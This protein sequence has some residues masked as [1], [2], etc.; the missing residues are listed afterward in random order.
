MNGGCDVTR[1]FPRSVSSFLPLQA[2][3][4]MLTRSICLSLAKVTQNF[5]KRNYYW[6]G[7]EYQKQRWWNGLRD[8]A[9]E[10][11]RFCIPGIFF[12]LTQ[13]CMNHSYNLISLRCILIVFIYLP[14]TFNESPPPR[15]VLS[16]G[17]YS[18]LI[19]TPF[20][21]RNIVTQ[22]TKSFRT[23]VAQYMQLSTTRIKYIKH[24]GATW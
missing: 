16:K 3:I 13:R 23:G 21:I 9:S 19:R 1:C 18:F 22:N 24:R 5:C 4:A 2:S 17:V 11:W 15:G 7:G 14:F 10:M 20:N 8:T 12:L 6:F